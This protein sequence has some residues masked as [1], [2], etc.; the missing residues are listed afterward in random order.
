[1]TLTSPNPSSS[2]SVVIITFN[3]EKNIEKCIRSVEGLADE[4]IVLDSFSSDRTAELVQQLGGKVFQ[5]KFDGYGA[6]KNAATALATNNHIL[7]LDADELLSEELRTSIMQEKKK[8]FP[9]DGYIMNRLNHYCGKWIRHGS[10]YPDKKLRILNRTKGEWSLDIV[11]ESLESREGSKIQHI[12]GDLLHYTYSTFEEHVD[13]NNRYSSLSAQLLYQKGKKASWIK[14][15]FNPFWA[16]FTSYFIR[17]GFLDGLY[18]YII[19][20]N[21]AHLTFLKYIKLYQLQQRQ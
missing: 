5:R 1:M 20:I 7:F 15:I 12:K 18:G 19:A 2:L 21:I 9:A 10:W 3:E 16:F 14:I 6:Q 11:H 17:G 4:I 8:N 13:K